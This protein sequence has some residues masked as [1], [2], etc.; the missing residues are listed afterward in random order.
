MGPDP[1]KIHASGLIDFL[2]P[3][4]DLMAALERFNR[5]GLESVLSVKSLGPFDRYIVKFFFDGI[6]PDESLGIEAVE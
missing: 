5:L 2:D 3:N 6:T 4:L 1:K